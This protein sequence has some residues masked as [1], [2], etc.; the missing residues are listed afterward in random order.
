MRRCRPWLGT[1]VEVECD[2][3]AAAEAAFA[4]IAQV[5]HLMSAHE[6][7]S[8]LSRINRSGHRQTVAVSAPTADVLRRARRWAE[9]SGGAFDIVQAGRDSLARGALPRHPG[10]PAPDSGADWSTVRLDGNDVSLDRPACLDLGGIA[11]GYAVDLAVA[12]MREAG[13]AR[14]LV[15]A[16]GDLRLFGDQPLSIA[17]PDPQS[18]QPL[19]MTMLSN[20]ALATSAGLRA[21]SADLPEPLD[22]LDFSHLPRSARDWISV[23]VRAP[24]ACDAD[25]LAKIVWAL[26][27][28]AEALVR[29]HQAEAFVI[30]CARQIHRVGAVEVIA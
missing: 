22:R 3:L 6:P 17:V 21:T 2:G 26:G 1:Y 8:E 25:A 13:A 18:R 4:A 23:T 27:Q 10:Q 9:V 11:K 30:D 19:V 15:N 24:T 7:D 16:G 14:G 28:S 29:D 12:A 20:A 5:H